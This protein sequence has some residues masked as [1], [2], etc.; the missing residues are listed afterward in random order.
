MLSNLQRKPV[1]PV[2]A[3]GNL[4]DADDTTLSD[5]STEEDILFQTAL[6]LDATNAAGK[7]T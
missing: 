3:V 5:D 4:A 7:V 6:Q 1:Q 2:A